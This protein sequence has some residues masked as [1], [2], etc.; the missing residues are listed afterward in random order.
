[1]ATKKPTRKAPKKVVSKSKSK[2]KAK[3]PQAVGLRNALARLFPTFSKALA[4]KSV[5]NG[6][7]N[8][9]KK[10]KPVIPMTPSVNLLPEEY[11]IV[12]TIGNIRRATGIVGFGIVASLGAVFYV[13]GAVIEVAQG[14]SD[15]VESQVREANF[16]VDSFNETTGLYALLNERKSVAIA[17]EGNIPEY[18]GAL[19]ALYASLPPGSVIT[20]IDIKYITLA[21]EGFE[22]VPTGLLCGPIADPF[23]TESREI[24]ACISAN[25]ITPTRDSFNRLTENLTASPLFSNVTVNQGVGAS[26]GGGDPF[27]IFAGLLKD[28]APGSVVIPEATDPVNIDAIENPGMPESP[29]STPV[30]PQPLPGSNETLEQTPGGN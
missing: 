9:K 3:S 25:G 20:N 27:Q 13:Q 28:I 15:S 19:S 21:K 18:Y 22:G 24:S 8:V 11:T 16:K 1:M 29:N 6:T 7:T 4:I 12:R 23:S 17:L 26:L 30:E 5:D 2:S 14:I 10:I